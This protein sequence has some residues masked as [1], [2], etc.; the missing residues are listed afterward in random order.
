[1]SAIF[2]RLGNMNAGAMKTFSLISKLIAV[3]LAAGSLTPAPALA[4]AACY[5]QSDSPMAHGLNTGIFSLLAVA[6]IV[7]A[8]IAMFFV[9]VAR[10]SGANSSPSPPLEERDRERRP[11]SREHLNSIAVAASSPPPADTAATLTESQSQK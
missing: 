2:K 3:A 5:G 11:F 8:S 4:C 1:M 7:L 6:G 10:R 9:H